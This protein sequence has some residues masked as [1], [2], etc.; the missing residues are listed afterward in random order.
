MRIIVF[1][2]FL[3]SSAGTLTALSVLLDS[4][5]LEYPCRS[6]YWLLLFHCSF[7]RRGTNKWLV[8]VLA[9]S[10]PLSASNEQIWSAPSPGLVNS[11]CLIN[12]YSRNEFI[13]FSYNYPLN[14]C[15][16]SNHTIREI[17]WKMDIRFF[18]TNVLFS[19]LMC[20][21]CVILRVVI[22]SIQQ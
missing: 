13:M 21:A 18:S 19:S 15:M 16:F 17:H 4:C 3:F 8:L 9:R 1:P 5:F 14:S 20:F 12:I 11:R 7:F 10:V 2:R 6:P 22:M